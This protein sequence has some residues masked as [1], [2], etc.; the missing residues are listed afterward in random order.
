MSLDKIF[1]FSPTPLL[2][3][4]QLWLWKISYHSWSSALGHNDYLV[5]QQ[6]NNGFSLMSTWSFQKVDCS[7]S[8]SQCPEHVL[9]VQHRVNL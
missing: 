7:G 5:E 1:S 8:W 6:R 2:A 9:S 4:Y 3:R